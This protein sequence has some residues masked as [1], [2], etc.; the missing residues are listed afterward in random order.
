M[1]PLTR[2]ALT[3]I[4][5]F[6]LCAVAADTTGCAAAASNTAC[7]ATPF[8]IPT[9]VALDHSDTGTANWQT[10][11]TGY[12]Y[13]SGCAI[14][15]IAIKYTW[16]VSDTIDAT[17]SS[18]GVVS[19]VNATAAPITVFRSIM[20]YSGTGNTLVAQN[21]PTNLPTANLTWK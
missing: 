1:S 17:V 5:A 11:C 19:C 18:D 12:R 16:S 6:A 4:S 21:T 8:I 7:S 9:S 13:S 14:P 2:Y 10:F 15:A 3:L 20:S